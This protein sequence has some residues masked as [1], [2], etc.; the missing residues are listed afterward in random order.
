VST[1]KDRV[2]SVS[3][4]TNGGDLQRALAWVLSD[5]IF[6]EVKLHGNVTWTAI[7][8]VR[9][10]V[11]WAW[12]PESSL[13]AAADTA[14]RLV[15]EI[16]GKAAVDSYHG[17]TTALKRYTDQ[18]LPV[19][20][21]RLHTLMK[22]CDENEWRVGPWLALAMDGS[23]VG[24]P[25]TMQNEQAFCKP[26]RGMAKRSRKS[27]T[28]TRHAN[29]KRSTQRHKQHYD[30]QPVGPQM[31]LTMIWHIGLKL[32][33]CWATGPSY[34]SERAHVLKVLDEEQFP[35]HTLFCGD[36]GFV[37]YEFWSQIQAHGHDFLVRVGG[38]VRLL[39]KLGYARE[40]NGLVYC[41][42]DE[43]MKKKR[44]PLVLRLLHFKD[45]R[46]DVY[47][48]TSVLDR[49]ALTDGQASEIYRQR[50]GIELQFRSLKQTFQR[51]KLRSHSPECAG[52]ELHWS[53]IALWVVQLLAVT[54]RTKIGEPDQKT[55]VA[56][57]IRIVRQIMSNH[58]AKR[59]PRESLGRRLATATTD[60]YARRGKKKSRNYP[61]RKEEPSTGKPLI[62]IA[63][64]SHKQKLRQIKQLANAA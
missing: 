50:W 61:R 32:P 57:A 34:S 25:R 36:A 53:L 16:F 63:T 56:A 5:D 3:A 58:A 27:K 62:R 30:P 9:L 35:A 10:A 28:R 39:K 38:N 21:R 44:P 13:V 64:A 42:P 23:R 11:F 18:I 41:W 6:D 31:W 29:R 22:Q 19:L 26:A 48:V 52:I 4:K 8:L 49:E 55:S 37:G 59:P 47:L 17:L 46:G 24:A 12:S 2:T 1:K 14:V 15:R 20:W 51:S 7:S 54:E 33:W 40:R 60:R 45:A 43:A